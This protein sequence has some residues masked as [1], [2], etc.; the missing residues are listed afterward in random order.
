MKSILIIG[1]NLYLLRKLICSYLHKFTKFWLLWNQ[2]YKDFF[3]RMHC[4]GIFYR[5]RFI[6]CQCVT[7]TTVSSYSVSV[8][9]GPMWKLILQQ[10]HSVLTCHLMIPT[11]LVYPLHHFWNPVTILFI[12]Q[13]IKWHSHV[14][15]IHAMLVM[16]AQL[17][18]TANRL[19]ELVNL[20][21]VL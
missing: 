11:R 7:E 2:S 18:V 12:L 9:T 8:W 17:I 5:H 6:E 10:Q 20:T 21:P 15:E 1:V 3:D 19:Q 16:Y 13:E 4:R 14:R